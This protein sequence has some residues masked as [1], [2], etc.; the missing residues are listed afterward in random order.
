M[1]KT[2]QLFVTV[3]T[4]TH[5]LN[6]DITDGGAAIVTASLW[7]SLFFPWLRVC[8]DQ[9]TCDQPEALGG[10]NRHTITKKWAHKKQQEDPD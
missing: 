9:A 6:V 2:H 3:P 4:I 5:V 1:S 10:T 8:Q 7:I